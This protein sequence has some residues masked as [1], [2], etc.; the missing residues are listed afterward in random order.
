MWIIAWLR[1][2]MTQ[3]ESL[4]Q[5]FYALKPLYRMLLCPWCCSIWVGLIAVNVIE[6][7]YGSWLLTALAVSRGANLLND[8][9][10]GF[11]RTPKQES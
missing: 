9:T 10:Y 5:P 1:E 2:Y 8:L 11:V 3:V 6:H 7:Q 4:D